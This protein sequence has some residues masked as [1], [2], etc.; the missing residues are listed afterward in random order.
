[1]TKLHACI[2]VG[3]KV[4]NKIESNNIYSILPF[5]RFIYVYISLLFLHL[6]IYI[7]ACKCKCIYLNACILLIEFVHVFLFSFLL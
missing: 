5:F 6:D 3:F 2:L 1:M 7:Y 4:E